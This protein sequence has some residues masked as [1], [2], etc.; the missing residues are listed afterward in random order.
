MENKAQTRFRSPALEM[1]LCRRGYGSRYAVSG[2]HP[3]VPAVRM[4]HLALVAAKL[5]VAV[6]LRYR[7]H[8]E[9]RQ[10]ILEMRA[11]KRAGGYTD[12][13]GRGLQA[14]RR[15]GLVGELL[16]QVGFLRD[17]LLAERDRLGLHRCD[18]LADL[19]SL[20]G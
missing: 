4:L 12:R 20:I 15:H 8:V 5:G 7:E 6:G 17:Q 16:V 14:L 11:A 13:V 9:S 1:C 19:R 10:V 18:Q 3:L 2:R